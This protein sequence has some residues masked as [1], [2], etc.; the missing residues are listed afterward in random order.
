M[1][2]HPEPVRGE[3]RI[4]CNCGKAGCVDFLNNKL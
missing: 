1:T 2:A 3:F 4:I